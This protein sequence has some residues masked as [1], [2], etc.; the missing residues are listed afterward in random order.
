M[1][2][3]IYHP[4]RQGCRAARECILV[5][6]VCTIRRASR[7]ETALNRFAVSS[8]MAVQVPTPTVRSICTF[9][10]ESPWQGSRKATGLPAPKGAFNLTHAALRSKIG[11]ADR[12]NGYPPPITRAQETVGLSASVKFTEVPALRRRHFDAGGRGWESRRRPEN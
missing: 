2:P 1:A 10:N 11:S 4:L 8:W 5:D 3:I 9:Q 12:I 6:H 7:L